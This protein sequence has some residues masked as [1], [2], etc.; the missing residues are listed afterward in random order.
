[1]ESC[2]PFGPNLKPVLIYDT[3]INEYLEEWNLPSRESPASVLVESTE[4]VRSTAGRLYR[5]FA[6]RQISDRD[7]CNA[8]TTRFI[9]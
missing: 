2:D 5:Q 4:Y 9:V 1:M 6:C 8:F 3:F 7:L